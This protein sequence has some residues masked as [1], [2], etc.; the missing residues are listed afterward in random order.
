M[1]IFMVTSKYA[2]ALQFHKGDMKEAL[3]NAMLIADLEPEYNK[4]VMFILFAA[5]NIGRIKNTP[6]IQEV[7]KHVSRKFPTVAWDS[8]RRGDGYPHGPND[9][10]YEINQRCFEEKRNGRIGCKTLFTIE[11]DT[12]PTKRNWLNEVFTEYENC[13]KEVLGCISSFTGTDD[14]L[15]VNGNMVLPVDFTFR[16]K[17]SSSPANIAWDVYHRNVFLPVAAHSKSIFNEYRCNEQKIDQYLANPKSL[18][19]VL[20]GYKGG[21]LRKY[22]RKKYEI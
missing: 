13:G 1:D 12:C 3:E 7:Q 5:R 11:A 9:M 2:V 8:M 10:W 20:H 21:K 14:G 18:P 22:V 6:E 17:L 19:T 16:Y 4:D 15:H